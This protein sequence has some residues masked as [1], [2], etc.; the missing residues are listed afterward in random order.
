M[1]RLISCGGWEILLHLNFMAVAADH[2]ANA[3]RTEKLLV[4]TAEQPKHGLPSLRSR[5]NVQ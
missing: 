5:G 2:P 3:S 1:N 4:T